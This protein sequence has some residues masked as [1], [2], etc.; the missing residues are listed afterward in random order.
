MSKNSPLA[1]DIKKGLFWSYS[2]LVLSIW[3][4]AGFL[5]VFGLFIQDQTLLELALQASF[6]ASGSLGCFGLLLTIAFLRRGRPLVDRRSRENKAGL[7]VTFASLWLAA[8]M[9][10]AWLA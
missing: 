3:A 2:T 4:L 6:L 8:Y 1:H 10:Y 9:L 5:P 7:V